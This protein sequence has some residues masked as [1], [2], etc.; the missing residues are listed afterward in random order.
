MDLGRAFVVGSKD[1]GES[2]VLAQL[3]GRVLGNAQGFD[4]RRGMGGQ[5]AFDALAAGEIDA[6]VDYTGTVWSNVM[7]REDLPARSAILAQMS[8]WLARERGVV[9]VAPMGF[10]NA[11]CLAVRAE[12]AERLGAATISDLAAHSGGVSLGSDPEFFERSDWVALRDAYG[13]GFAR[14]VSMT[15]TLMYPAVAGGEVDAITAYTTDGRIAAMGL[16]VLPDDRGALPPYDAVL[17]LSARA[18]AEPGV[19]ARLQRLAGRIDAATMQ[20]ANRRVDIEG[21]S[22]EAVAGWLVGVV[23]SE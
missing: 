8:G 23:L 21:E 15:P 4:H 9:V 7:G 6:Y 17:L 1:F 14:L 13:L 18:A 12:T 20:E 5:I 19:V 11:Y 2:E 3:A 22:V 10:E 16:V